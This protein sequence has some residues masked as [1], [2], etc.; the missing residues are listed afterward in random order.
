MATSDT[1]KITQCTCKHDFQDKHYGKGLRVH[2]LA[3]G[4]VKGWRCT[5]CSNIKATPDAVK[6]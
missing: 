3:T 1:T 5:V 6:K 2:N 4:K